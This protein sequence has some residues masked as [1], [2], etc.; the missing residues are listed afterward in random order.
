MQH[1]GWQDPDGVHRLDSRRVLAARGSI[2]RDNPD[3]TPRSEAVDLIRRFRQKSEDSE[4]RQKAVRWWQQCDRFISGEQ[5]DD[6]ISAKSE[7][8][9]Q[10]KSRLV[11]N[12]LYRIREKW[13]SLLMENIPK[14]EFIARDPGNA[15]VAD[16]LDAFFA[17]EWER[18]G[19]TTTIG[20]V[21][22][23]VLSHGIGWIKVFW[24]V[25]GDGGRGTVKLEA[26]S[27]YD[28]FLDE[29]AKI[30]GGKL[31]C[32]WAIHRFEMTRE[33]IL[34]NYEDDP[35]GALDMPVAESEGNGMPPKSRF[36]QYVENLN[37]GGSTRGS[38]AGGLNNDISERHPDHAQKKDVFTVNEC[39]YFDDTR[40]EGPAI[41]NAVG[42]IPSLKYPSGRVMT[43]TEGRLLYDDANRLGFNYFVPFCLSPD[44]ERIYNPS[45]IY[46]CISPQQELNKRR[47]QISDHAALASN[48]ILVV[49]QQSQVDQSFVPYPGAVLV[50]MDSQSPDGGIR[51]LI[52]PQQSPE[53]VQSA[54]FAENDIDRIAGTD[55]IERGQR[56]NQ[57]E[58]GV[59]VERVQEATTTVPQ[60]HT[61]FLDDNMKVLIRNI[62]SL[63]LDF[64][65]DDRK[66]RFMDMRMLQYQYGD[67]NP[68]QM[69]VPSR[70]NA[71]SAVQQELNTLHQQLLDAQEMMSPEEYEELEF[72]IEQEM[73]A[74]L[75]K[76]DEI[77]QM[78]ASDLVS[79]DVALQ[80]GTRN[81]TQEALQALVLQMYELGLVVPATLLDMLKF[82][83]WEIALQMK[84]EQ[85]AADAE[86]EQQ[87]I[88]DQI[89]TEREI[90]EDEHEQDIEIEHIKGEYRLKEAEIKARAQRAAARDRQKQQ[91]EST[92]KRG[93]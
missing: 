15:F 74:R 92:T 14:A 44:V 91:S 16:T 87:Q 1:E 55:E 23:Q 80:T 59:G 61:T 48:P 24:D 35:G 66:Y 78:P 6:P 90:D 69:L 71:V 43:E 88:D 85:D 39:L 29:N 57:L 70:E 83:N 12:H 45:I 18:N 53:V 10:W 41:D 56:T 9:I 28:L 11:I 21:L 47:S 81:F 86:A 50:S 17:H 76:I 31:V 19:W 46:Q 37:V 3:D 2:H 93:K 68:V 75:L 54:V 32:K 40:V 36:S 73:L 89:E 60:M 4:L 22:K 26:V 51:W 20:K 82:P 27:N 58:S 34:S 84:Q 38:S 63:F 62:A 67:F 64:V 7:Q 5:W 72:H 49:T 8:D 79:F 13:A 52:P 25:H 77:W 33:D 42:Q 30:D 65:T